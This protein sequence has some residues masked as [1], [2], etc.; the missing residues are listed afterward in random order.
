[1]IIKRYKKFAEKQSELPV[2]CQVNVKIN[3][4]VEKVAEQFDAIMFK[5][6]HDA[7]FIVLDIEER[8]DN[9]EDIFLFNVRDSECVTRFLC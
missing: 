5:L 6:I 3:K 8:K 9:V 7:H 1:L 2:I 4:V